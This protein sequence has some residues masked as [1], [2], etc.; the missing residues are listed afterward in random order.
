MGELKLYVWPEFLP[1]YTPGLAVALAYS[2]EEAM[3]MIE[4]Q[5]PEGSWLTKRQP[6]DWGP[7]EVHGLE[8]PVVFSVTG[9]S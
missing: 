7:L 2:E 6:R 3:A 8:S 1:D 5:Y 9:G 4:K